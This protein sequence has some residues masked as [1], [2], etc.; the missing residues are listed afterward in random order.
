MV[1]LE[2]GKQITHITKRKGDRMKHKM[3]SLLAV[4]TICFLPQRVL[5]QT[6]TVEFESGTDIE[7]QSGADISA[8]VITVNGTYSGSGTFNG[9]PLPVEMTAMTAQAGA[10]DVTISWKTSTETDNY[11]FEVE[12]R[13]VPGSPTLNI[14]PGTWNTIGFVQGA[15]TSTSPKEYSFADESVPPGR[16]AYRIKQIDQGGSFSYTAALEV[17]VGLAPK[18][19]K[20]SENYP[21]PFNPTTVIEFTIPE[22]GHVSLRLYDM[23]GQAVMTMVDEERSAGVYHQMTINASRLSSGTYFARLEFGGTQLTRR[24][25]LVK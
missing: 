16:Y 8:D 3:I 25:L 14:E 21:N 19:L 11:G 4:A 13:A 24:M 2:E 17:E 7:V 22:D 23:T 5:S 1:R 12:R 10:R 9:G 18:L 15:G 20:L 6:S